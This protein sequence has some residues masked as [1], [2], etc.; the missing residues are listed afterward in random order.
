MHGNQGWLA[1]CVRNT[2]D[3]DVWALKV[4]AGRAAVGCKTQDAAGFLAALTETELKRPGE[5]SGEQTACDLSVL[6]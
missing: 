1:G 5:L 2:K 4:R 6:R 3:R